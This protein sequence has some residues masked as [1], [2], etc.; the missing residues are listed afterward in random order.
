MPSAGHDCP[1]VPPF[2]ESPTAFFPLIDFPAAKQIAPPFWLSKKTPMTRWSSESAQWE[3]KYKTS[4]SLQQREITVFR[5]FCLQTPR[6]LKRSMR[7]TQ[8]CPLWAWNELQTPAWLYFGVTASGL[9]GRDKHCVLRLSCRSH[10]NQKGKKKQT[11]PGEKRQAA[12]ED[13]V[14]G[15]RK[16]RLN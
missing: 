10:H 6:E 2:Q 16:E 1:V 3:N 8:P 15:L 7:S 5:L 13:E 9:S 12:C 14:C 11:Q 4:L